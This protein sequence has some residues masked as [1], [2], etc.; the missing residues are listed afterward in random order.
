MFQFFLFAACALT[1]NTYLYATCKRHVVKGLTHLVTRSYFRSRNEDGG[2]AIRY[3]VAENSML[4]ANFNALCVIDAELL[5]ME[6]SRC[7]DRSGVVVQR[8]QGNTHCGPFFTPVTLTLTRWP[9]HT[10]L[11]RIPWRCTGCANIWPILCWWDVK[12]YSIN[13]SIYS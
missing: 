13:Q 1:H 6:C 8:L 2:H 7:A 4:H 3:T 12:P 5:A 11:T 9:S 10:N